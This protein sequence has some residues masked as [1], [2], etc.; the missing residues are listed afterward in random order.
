MIEDSA[1]PVL[2][3]SRQTR[4]MPPG[5]ARAL[6]LVDEDQP[7]AGAAKTQKPRRDVSP[8]NLA[9]VIYTSGSTGRP[10]GVQVTH[11]SVVNFLRSMEAEPGLDATDVLVAVTSLSFDIAALE[12]F[13]PLVSGGRVVV[14][15]REAAG[16]GDA[17]TKLLDDAQAT[18]MQAT[19]S[20]WRM[21]LESG[22]KGGSNFKALCGGEALAQ[23]LA[24]ELTS[25]GVRG[26]WNLY[27]PTETTIWSSLELVRR[28]ER[29]VSIG[30]PIEQTQIYILDKR[31][32][33]VPLGVAGELYIAG[34]GVARGYLRR[35]GLTAERFVPDPYGRERGGRMYRTGD[36]A[37]HLPDGRVECLGRLDNQVKLRGHR[38]ELGEVEAAVAALGGIRECVVSLR[39]DAPG[40][41]RLVA[42]VVF[43]GE[44]NAGELRHGLKGRLPDYMIPSTFVV[45]D[46]L[47]LTPNG[48]VD[49]GRLPA[50]DGAAQVG[51][52][53]PYVAPRTHVEEAL[54]GIWAAALGVERV[55]VHDD[56]FQLGGHSLTAV[57]VVSRVRA[58]LRME[59]PLKVFVDEAPTV[60]KL[61]TLVEI[62]QIEQ[63]SEQELSSMLEDLNQL[64]EDEVKALLANQDALA[65]DAEHA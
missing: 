45:L 48:K 17:L 56:F 12:L 5:G 15:S 62:S 49:R 34:D 1:A 57:L 30:R 40:D 29:R 63:A 64:S 28:E 7:L 27:G 11:R 4:H 19:P 35:A 46:A 47:P 6:L 32:E 37:R 55:G 14:A 38:I 61:A 9:Y 52:D 60:E 16:E 2:I 41:R 44:R 59:I 54:A 21:L 20:T 26:V 10:K 51:A 8:D 24:E 53:R 31:H 58:A 25:L 22:W 36:L 50:P 3:A 23:D 18:A 33:A 42:Y 39:E 65:G 43:D 13:L